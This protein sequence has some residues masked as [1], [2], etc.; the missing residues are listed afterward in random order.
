[1]TN[2]SMLLSEQISRLPKLTVPSCCKTCMGVLGEPIESLSYIV[3]LHLV[4][5]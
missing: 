2:T 3:I 5:L 1:M 4:R